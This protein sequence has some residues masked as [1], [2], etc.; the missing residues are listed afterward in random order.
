MET[1]KITNLKHLFFYLS[2]SIVLFSSLLGCKDDTSDTEEP[3]LGEKNILIS[4]ILVYEP[5]CGCDGNTYSNSCIA[6]AEGVLRFSS[7][8]CN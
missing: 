6:E 4:C 7:G 2:F 5:V 1:P 3:C 8:E